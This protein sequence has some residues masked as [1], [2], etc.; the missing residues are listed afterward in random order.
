MESILKMGMKWLYVKT[1][2]SWCAN[3]L[4]CS[5]NDWNFGYFIISFV[6]IFFLHSASYI[7]FVVIPTLKFPSVGMTTD[8]YTYTMAAQ[9]FFSEGQIRTHGTWGQ[10]DDTFLGGWGHP[11]PSWKVLKFGS[12]KWHFKVLNGIFFNFVS[13]YFG[14]QII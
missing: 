2:F 10:N 13:Q 7:D 3:V 6:L 9:T 8:P 14:Y 12:L 5:Y 1:Y 11:P 4:E